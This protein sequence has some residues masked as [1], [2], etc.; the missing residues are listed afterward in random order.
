MGKGWVLIIF[1]SQDKQTDSDKKDSGTVFSRVRG[2]AKIKNS[3][4]KNFHNLGPRA[5]NIEV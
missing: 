1:L 2:V 4:F 3:L 5:S